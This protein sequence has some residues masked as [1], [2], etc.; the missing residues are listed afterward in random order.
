MVAVEAE[1]VTSSQQALG[2]V[3]PGTCRHRQVTRHTVL[4]AELSC[5]AVAAAAVEV[6]AGSRGEVHPEEADDV[7]M[8]QHQT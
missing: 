5:A 1:A 6:A 2:V 8:A 4:L 7:A 3:H